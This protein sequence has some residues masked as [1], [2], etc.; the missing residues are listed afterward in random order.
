MCDATIRIGDENFQC[1]AR[2]GPHKKHKARML[3]RTV[4]WGRP[5]KKYV[6]VWFYWDTGRTN[7][8]AS[9]SPAT[10]QKAASG[11]PL[12]NRGGLDASASGPVDSDPRHEPGGGQ[13]DASGGLQRLPPDRRLG[14]YPA[15]SRGQSKAL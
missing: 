12:S 11:R 8:R 15:C 6:A 10:A 14:D 1:L 2:G 7:D 13:P 4:R 3:A 9:R 5:E